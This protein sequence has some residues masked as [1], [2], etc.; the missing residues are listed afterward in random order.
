[1][2]VELTYACK[3]GCTHCL[4]DCKPDGEHMSIDTF[5]DVLKFMVDHT[6]PTWMFSGGEMFEHPEILTMLDMIESAHKDIYNKMHMRL[7]IHLAPM[8]V[9]WCV[10]KQYTMLLPTCKNVSANLAS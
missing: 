10:T 1:M 4:S 8:D 9:N 3:T 7:P 6:I 2:L 5:K